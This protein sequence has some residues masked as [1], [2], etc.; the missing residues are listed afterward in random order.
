MATPP[1]K[2][3]SDDLKTTLE[4]IAVAGGY[5]STV[6]RVETVLREW[7]EIGDST[8]MPWLGFMLE[9]EQHRHE[10]GGMLWVTLPFVI[11]GYVNVTEDTRRGVV[12]N[13]LDDIIKALHTDT[14]RGGNAVVTT[15]TEQSTD[16][17]D[18][19]FLVSKGG[20]ARIQVKGTVEYYRTT[21]G[22]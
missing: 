2:L 18:P 21:Q 9:A 12:S 15:I 20:E 11:V 19:D 4:A 5:K 17:A 10:P 16:E 13:L 14:T 1:R 6:V 8:Q 22:S 3:I 7:D